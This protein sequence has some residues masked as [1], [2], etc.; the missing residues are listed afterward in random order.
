M[1]TIDKTLYCS[2]V[3][4]IFAII[5]LALFIDLILY[6]CG[7]PTVSQLLRAKP[8]CFWIPAGVMVAFIVLLALHLFG[9][10]GD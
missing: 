7:Q 8:E 5:A 10:G 4:G 6:L 3:V 9:W 2:A 1:A